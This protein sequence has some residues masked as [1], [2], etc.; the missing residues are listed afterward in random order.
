MPT[1]RDIIDGAYSAV[2]QSDL[3]NDATDLTVNGGA[4][5]TVKTGAKLV[6]TG[7]C[8]EFAFGGRL[9]EQSLGRI[10]GRGKGG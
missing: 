1:D 9:L 10:G 2:L 6:M 4:D 5:L 3:V 7:G 8:W